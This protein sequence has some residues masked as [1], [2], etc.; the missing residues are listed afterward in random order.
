M[1]SR[2]KNPREDFIAGQK[3]KSLCNKFSGTLCDH[4]IH[5]LI[6]PPLYNVFYAVCIWLNED[7]PD[8]EGN[9]DEYNF[10]EGTDEI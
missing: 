1:D 7:R 2:R 5:R 6:E 3:D 8:S 9:S 4:R 10:C